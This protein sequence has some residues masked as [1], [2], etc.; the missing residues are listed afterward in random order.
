M[1]CVVFFLLEGIRVHVRALLL[2]K[3]KNE[4]TK[5]LAGCMAAVPRAE[6]L[7]LLMTSQERGRHEF[8]RILE[9][10]SPLSYM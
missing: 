7:L 5:D 4:R 1:F 3:R 6:V 2:L 8:G 10:P 9:C